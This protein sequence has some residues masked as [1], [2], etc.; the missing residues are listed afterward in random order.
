MT[1]LDPFPLDQW[2][3]K[4]TCPA[5]K[6]NCLSRMT[7]RGFFQGQIQNKI[8]MR[9][10]LWIRET[11]EPQQT[12]VSLKPLNT[13]LPRLM[14]HCLTT[15]FKPWS[16]FA[17]ES[18]WISMLAKR[19]GTRNKSPEKFLLSTCWWL[20]WTAISYEWHL[21]LAKEQKDFQDKTACYGRSRKDRLK[22][23]FFALNGIL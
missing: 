8:D 14:L 2:I 6:S 12:L 19:K 16:G 17:L 5:W 7:G 18:P 20:V 9:E 11:D 15:F 23:F 21:C 3:L 22:A 1:S 13:N 4:A 10:I